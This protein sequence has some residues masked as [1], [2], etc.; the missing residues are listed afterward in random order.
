MNTSAMRVRNEYFSNVSATLATTAS[1]PR[2]AN[3]RGF[4]A[5]RAGKVIGI[6]LVHVA[7]PSAMYELALA[8]LIDEYQAQGQTVVTVTVVNSD[9]IQVA[10]RAMLAWPFPDLNGQDSPAGP[11][12][13]QNQFTITSKFPENT[14][15]P[16]AFAVYDANGNLISDVI[17]GYGQVVGRGHISGRVTFKQRAGVLP[18]DPEPQPND[19]VSLTRIAV[20]IERLAKHLGA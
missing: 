10:E 9:G 1:D 7:V 20:A 15:G 8:E 14:V 3:C 18:P 4:L 16:L 6:H 12:N 2:A 19:D 17:G 5:D 11:G 13:P